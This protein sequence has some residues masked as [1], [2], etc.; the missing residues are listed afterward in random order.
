M[1]SAL[2]DRIRSHLSEVKV[3]GNYDKVYKDEC[4]YC[5]ASPESTDGIFVN[6]KNWHGVGSRF[7]E[8]DHHRTGVSLYYNEEHQRIPLPEEAADAQEAAPTKMAI[9]G[10][11][12]FQVNKKRY[13]I[14]KVSRL[15]VMPDKLSVELPCPDL[16]ELI[17][18]AITAIQVCVATLTIMCWL[19]THGTTTTTLQGN[20]GSSRQEQ[21]S[22][23]EE[24]RKESKYAKNL[25]QLP[26][27]RKISP[28]P[29]DWECEF[30]GVKDNLWLNLSTGKIGSGRR[31]WDG[32]GGN[33][34]LSARCCAHSF[35]MLPSTSIHSRHS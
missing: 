12:G 9:G 15:V 14:A 24:E 3:P 17:L 32:S 35:H 19:A 6:M 1:D 23:W 20:E 5:F 26:P 7:L 27:E 13:E 29:S 2:L 25:E 8:L 30:T 11:Q 22:T 18:Q 33:G 4:M 21:T 31:H 34:M 16:P 28:N 10:D